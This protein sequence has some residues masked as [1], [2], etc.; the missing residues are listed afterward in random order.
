[1]YNFDFWISSAQI[2][3]CS[4]IDELESN[5]HFSYYFNATATPRDLTNLSYLVELVF[6]GLYLA[7]NIIFE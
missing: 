5:D 6:A 4:K 3:I 1:M 2:K 7:V